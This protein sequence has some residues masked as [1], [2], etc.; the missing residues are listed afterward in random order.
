MDNILS[1]FDCIFVN[2]NELPCI[3]EITRLL[4]YLLIFCNLRFIWFSVSHFHLVQASSNEA[5]R[6]AVVEEV[7][8]NSNADYEIA[9]VVKTR[10]LDVLE[11]DKH[12]QTLANKATE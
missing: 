5:A 10:I 7:Y 9:D 12:L 3:M 4:I 11:N 6:K 2:G 8:K 1:V